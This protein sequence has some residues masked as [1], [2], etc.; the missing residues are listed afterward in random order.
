MAFATSADVATYLRRGFDAEGT[1]AADLALD[2]A[3]QMIKSYTEQQITQ[4]TE[5]YTFLATSR[6]VLLLPELPVTAVASVVY[7]G[8]TLVVEEDYTWTR[9]GLVTKVAGDW[10]SGTVAVTYT[11][12]YATVPDDIRGVCIEVAK[13]AIENPA[14]LQRDDLNTASQWLGF[15]RENRLILDRYRG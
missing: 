3:T 8:A 9:Y 13:R 4:A 10:S 6:N 12:G 7:D 15:T 11:H 1:A 5:T 14:G 2:I